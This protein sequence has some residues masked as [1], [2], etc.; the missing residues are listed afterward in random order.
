MHRILVAVAVVCVT[1]MGAAGIAALW[2]GW[3]PRSGRGLVLRPKMWGTGVL[4]SAFG[5]TG[6]MFLRP[7]GAMPPPFPCLPLAGMALNLVG[8][9]L[10]SLARRPG[11]AAH[12][13]SA[14]RTVS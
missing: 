1:V 11:R 4:L 2:T 10:Q 5:L 13:P 14:T 8:L 6:F 3:T 12:P 9:A 7:L